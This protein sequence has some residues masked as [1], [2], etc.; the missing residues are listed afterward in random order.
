MTDTATPGPH[1]LGTPVPRRSFMKWSAAAGGTAAAVGVGAHYGLLPLAS[2]SAEPAAAGDDAKVVWSSCNVNCGSRCPLL[3]TVVDGQ[4]TRVDPDSTGDDELGSQQIRAC[5]RGRAIRQR[6]YNPDR[7][8][9]PMKRVG[10]RGAGEFEKITWEEAYD[11]IAASLKTTIEKYGN[12]A[13]YLNYGTGALGGTVAKSWPPASSPIARLMN[14]MGG[15]LNHYGTYS[16]AQ[17][18]AATPYTYGAGAGNNSFDDTVHSKLVVLWGNNPHETRMSG[19]GET[20]VTQEAK[21]LGGTKVIVIDPRYTDTAVTIADEWVPLRP[22][23]DAA[24]VAGLAHVMISEELHDQAFLDTY[25]VGFDEEHLP[26]GAPAGGSYKSYVLGL[27]PDAT[28]KTP[29]WAATITGIPATRIVQLA[30]TI[31]QAKPCAIVQGWGPQRHANGENSARAVMLLAA[32]TGNVG[33]QGGGTGAREGSYQLSLSA[34]PTLTNPV[35]TS[36]PVFMWTDAIERATEMT[37]TT[38]GIQG[39]DRLEVPI[40]FIWNY[41]GNALINQHADANRT[42]KLLEDDS[43][44]EMIVVI[45]NQMT[46]SAKFA[47]ILLPDV[48]NSEQADLVPQGSAGSLGY[49]IFA[50]QVIDPLFDCRTVYEM[51]TEL[52]ARAGVEEQFTEG[53]TQEDWL[54][55]VYSESQVKEPDL[56]SFEELREKGIW[57]KKNPAGTVIGLKKFRDDPVANPLKTPSG[58]IEIYSSLL[59]KL[60]A[61]WELPEGDRITPLPEYTPTWEGAEEAGSGKHP[62][63]MIGHHYKSRTHSTY[64]NVA[65]MKEAHP[66]VVWINTLDAQARSIENDDVVHVFNDRG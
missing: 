8:K 42:A 56:P 22:G 11:T 7:L 24:L 62:L 29:E 13:V 20:F 25:C 45:E 53:K 31:A 14:C 19:G 49:L 35:K 39:K 28:E 23:T 21:R 3:M 54:R 33:I 41:A 15:Y 26:E 47:D 50:D 12:E 40:K 34:F 37:A 27:G 55:Q 63:Q 1:L 58:K 17:I 16:T 9:Y 30:R 66:Q 52:A 10:K 6:I 18:S 57:K 60:D 44:C 43:L 48:S 38:D 4:I 2:A 51:C 36:I 61:T 64:G 46:A 65:W 32:L 5:V 59:A